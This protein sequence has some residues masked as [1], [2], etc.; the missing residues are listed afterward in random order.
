VSE[1][2]TR[3][4]RRARWSKRTWSR[5]RFVG[6]IALGGIA[7]WAVSG[8]GAELAGAS[9]ELSHL[10]A[11]WLLVAIGVEVLSLVAFAR[12]DQR[13]LACGGVSS[14]LGWFTTISFAAGA[15]ASSLP[16]GPLVASAFGFRQF[17]RLGASE[18]LAAWTLLATLVFSALG[19]ALLATAGVVVAEH[20]GAAF[21]LVGVI[22][23]VFAVTIAG[24]AV[25]YQ[26]RALAKVLTWTLEASHRITGFPRRPAEEIISAI[27]ASMSHVS[28]SRRD[29]ADVL[30][31]SVANWALDCSCLVFAYLA[32][33]AGVPW[34]GL[35][36]AYG[37]GQLAANLPIT[38]GGL[39]VVEGSLVIALVAFGGGQISTVAAVLLYR[40]VSFWGFL[41]V[42]WVFWGGLTWRNRRAD[43][44]AAR[45]T[46]V[47]VARTS[48]VPPP[49]WTAELEG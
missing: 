26:R 49:E 30:A 2:E 4:P 41:P 12:M 31:W 43:Q 44:A 37:A 3:A 16:A 18:T 8:Q 36:L 17:R 27:A 6:G 46:E 39:G 10:N 9:T 32:V 34:R 28:L 19:L 33:G 20:Q 45:A 35:L 1:S 42:G 21:D 7:L 48:A 25:V 15:I 24:V 29:L 5:I 11:G 14:G 47:P 38:P 13:L 22:V 40:I 23:A